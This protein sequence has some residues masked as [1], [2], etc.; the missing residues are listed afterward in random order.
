VAHVNMWSS[1]SWLR[2]WA[3]TRRP[4][5]VADR[6]FARLESMRCAMSFDRPL[7][8]ELV[9]ALTDPTASL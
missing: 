6:P 7:L 5:S 1:L 9:S 8:S 2:R 3:G 4:S